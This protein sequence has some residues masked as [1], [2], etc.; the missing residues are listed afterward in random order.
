MAIKKTPFPP[1]PVQWSNPTDPAQPY[2]PLSIARPSKHPLTLKD[3][4]YFPL[5]TDLGVPKSLVGASP[6]AS[7][8]DVDQKEMTFATTVRLYHGRQD[9]GYRRRA[10]LI[11]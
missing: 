9:P 4:L 8:H 6:Q 3:I 2:H 10:T 11:S 7:I 1:F 5:I